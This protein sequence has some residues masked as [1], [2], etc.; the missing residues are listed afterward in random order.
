MNKIKIKDQDNIRVAMS[1]G[2]IMK[3]TCLIANFLVV[4]LKKSKDTGEINL[5]C[6]Y[7]IQ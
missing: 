6:F 1:N 5:K 4:T 7:L 3:V 2:N